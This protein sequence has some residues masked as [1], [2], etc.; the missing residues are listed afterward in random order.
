MRV[1]RRLAAGGLV[2]GLVGATA[3]PAVAAEKVRHRTVFAFRD[4][5]INESSGLVDHHRLVVT[6]NDSGDRARLYVVNPSSGATVGVTSYAAQSTIDVEAISPGRHW[7]VWAGDIGDNA[8]RRSSIAVYHVPRVRAG[9]RGVAAKKFTLE[10]PDS[11]HNAETLLVNPRNQRVFVVTKS[12]FGATVYR[13]PKR[14]RTGTVNHLRA[15]ARVSGLL[16][17][18]TFFRNGKHVL[19]RTY[20]GA[21][22]YTFPG[23]RLVRTL[24]LPSQKQGEGISIGPHGRLLI[25]SE[26]VHSPVDRIWLPRNLSRRVMGYAANPTPGAG[27]PSAPAS[28]DHASGY[29]LADARGEAGALMTAAAALAL[30]WLLLRGARLHSPRSA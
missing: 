19:L 13:A 12:A 2:V 27:T 4:T 6:T 20:T 23:F 1:L 29:R 28:G 5:E 10:Y 16:T 21:A 17:D 11:A 30:G 22:V 25:S 8:E 14:L 7:S 9:N 15:F 26:G 3:A 24:Q 18:G